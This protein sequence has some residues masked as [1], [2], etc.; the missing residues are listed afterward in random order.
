MNEISSI[1]KNNII[2]LLPLY[3]PQVGDVTEIILLDQ[4]SIIIPNNIKTTLKN[5]AK[6]YAVD[7]KAMRKKYE[8]IFGDVK[9]AMPV[10]LSPEII[11]M[12]LKVRRIILKNDSARGY[13]NYFMIKNVEKNKDDS[14]STI[15][16]KNDRRIVCH[17]SMKNVNQH[18]RNCRYV[19]QHILKESGNHSGISYEYLNFPATKGDIALVLEELRDLK[20]KL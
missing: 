16:L 2:G 9:R 10:I 5:I 13:F 6:Y 11:L 8:K 12:T 4:D 19:H 20:N 14:F 15:V 3:Y 1:N 17:H 7:L 18:I